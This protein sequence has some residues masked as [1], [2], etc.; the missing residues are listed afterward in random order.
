MASVVTPTIKKILKVTEYDLLRIKV[1]MGNMYICLDSMKMYFDQG[2]SSTDRV[3]YN[4]I[5][6][7]TVNDLNTK[8][9]PMSN[10][11]YYC[12][13]DNSLWTWLDG[14]HCLYSDSTYPS[15]YR[16]D[17]I[18]S[19]DNPQ[20]V[21][22][23]YRYD[24]P[25]APA[26]D[27]GLLK[28]GSVVIRDINRLIKGRIY[29]EDSNDNLVVSSYLGGGIRFLP[30]GRMSTDGEL[31][32]GDNELSYIRSQFRVL[33]NELYVDYSEKPNEDNSEFPNEEHFYK[34]F[35]EGNLDTSAIRIM[36]PL[37]IYNKLLDNSLPNIFDFNVTQLEGHSSNEFAL[38]TH[39]HTGRDITDLGDLIEAE[40]NVQVAK[41][42]NTMSSRGI[43]SQ[44]NVTTNRLTLIA[45]P[46]KLS[47]GGGVTGS[48][49]IMN[50]EDT[51]I[52][53]NVLPDGHIHQDYLDTMDRLQSQID[54]CI[55]QLDRLRTGS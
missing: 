48:G 40:T 44:Y 53:L 20:G 52:V 4:Y 24:M 13:E 35:H 21:S 17:D 39:N 45:N 15:A 9:N 41:V 22:A 36:T 5:S 50:L 18:P 28:D 23:I 42:F 8:I 33:N 1:S 26:D 19:V 47:F 6:V 27:N 16:F 14:W 43:S 54:Y 49:D 25:N 12:W 30:N 11:V 38:Q 51:T 29:I 3:I 46:F 34:V 2:T 7:K 32:I 37:Q 31:V 55:E 10:Y